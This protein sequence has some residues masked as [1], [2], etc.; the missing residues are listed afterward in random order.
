MADLLRPSRR[1]AENWARGALS[2]NVPPIIRQTQPLG[3]Y[4]TDTI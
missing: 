4:Y 3:I 2:S 1:L